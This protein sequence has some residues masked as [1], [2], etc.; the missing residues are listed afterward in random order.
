MRLRCRSLSPNC[1][2]SPQISFNIFT[3]CI[4][5]KFKSY[6]PISLWYF[7]TEW[8]NQS[9]PAIHIHRS[10]VL[11]HV[12]F[13]EHP[14]HNSQSETRGDL[15]CRVRTPVTNHIASHEH[16]TSQQTTRAHVSPWQPIWHLSLR[17][18][19]EWCKITYNSQRY[20]EPQSLHL[21]HRYKHNLMSG[22]N[23][24]FRFFCEMFEN[25]FVWI[26]HHSTQLA[27]QTSHLITMS[28]LHKV[29][30]TQFN[31]IKCELDQPL[32]IDQLLT[33]R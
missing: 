9:T 5:I 3:A 6:L 23:T 19:T 25:C 22:E 30:W 27:F 13:L 17:T 20:H 10:H 31:W 12:R 2:K 16:V 26:Y 33:S 29:I 15:I 24:H 7:T 21:L 18:S 1:H 14:Q 4:Y 28:H 32:M 11:I 8:L